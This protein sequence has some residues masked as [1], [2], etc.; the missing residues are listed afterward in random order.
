MFKM[1]ISL[2]EAP[3]P[4]TVLHAHVEVHLIIFGQ[5]VCVCVCPAGTQ[6]L[7][8]QCVGRWSWGPDSVVTSRQGERSYVRNV[9]H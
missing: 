8:Q 9:H 7:S 2:S 3:G 5:H 1:S 4:L 6:R